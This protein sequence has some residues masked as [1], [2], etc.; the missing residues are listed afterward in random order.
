MDFLPP[1]ILQEIASFK[2]VEDEEAVDKV[3]WNGSISGG[4]TIKSALNIIRGQQELG[5]TVNWSRIWKI[6]YLKEYNFSCGWC[7]TL[8]L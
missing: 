3:Y 1:R 7:Y 2:L 8:E 5:A 6:Q 4:F